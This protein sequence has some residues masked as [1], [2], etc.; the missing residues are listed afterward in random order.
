MIQQS[1]PNES[2]KISDILKQDN[3]RILGKKSKYSR[4]VKRYDKM[5]E[6]K[7]SETKDFISKLIYDVIGN[8]PI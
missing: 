5:I 6:R 7:P 3:K 4:H 1:K 8:L 2:L